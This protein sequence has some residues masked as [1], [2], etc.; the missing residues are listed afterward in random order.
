[1]SPALC[2]VGLLAALPPPYGRWVCFRLC[3]LPAEVGCLRLRRLSAGVGF[4]CRLAACFWLWVWVLAFLL[5]PVLGGS[6]VFL[7]WVGLFGFF[8]CGRP[9]LP[10]AAAH[11]PAV[12][13]RYRVRSAACHRC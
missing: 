9:P 5:A 4:V 12:A 10:T 7:W 2:G 8:D 1:A 3:R 6:G 13:R 11:P